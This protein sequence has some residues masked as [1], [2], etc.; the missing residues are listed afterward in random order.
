VITSDVIDNIT[1]DLSGKFAN[2]AILLSNGVV[3]YNSTQ[4]I[5]VGKKLKEW[6]YYVDVGSVI[7]DENEV[8]FH[9]AKN[10]FLVIYTDQPDEELV[11]TF[12]EIYE[13]YSKT[14]ELTYTEVPR[15]LKDIMKGIIFST[16]AGIK[17][18]PVAWVPDKLFTE[19]SFNFSLISTILLSVEMEDAFS[20]MVLPR[21]FMKQGLLGLLY[22]F[23]I[24]S[25]VSRVEPLDC[26]FVILV[27]ISNRAAV[28][29]IIMQIEGI[30]QHYAK[31]IQDRMRDKKACKTIIS[32]MFDTVGAI[33]L[34]GVSLSENIKKVMLHSVEEMRELQNPRSSLQDEPPDDFY[35]EVKKS[36]VKL[37]LT[38]P[39]LRSNRHI[40]IHRKNFSV[41][42]FRLE[43][44]FKRWKS[45]R[46]F[47][48]LEKLRRPRYLV[49]AL[50]SLIRDFIYLPIGPF[51]I[52]EQY[53]RIV[54]FKYAI[55]RSQRVLIEF[56]RA[57]E[58]QQDEFWREV[59]KIYAS[60][61][62]EIDGPTTHAIESLLS[63]LFSPGVLIVYCYVSEIKIIGTRAK[64]Y[65]TALE[66]FLENLPERYTPGELGDIFAD[67]IF[68]NQLFIVSL[69]G[70]P[71]AKWLLSVINAKNLASII[72]ERK[73]FK[74]K[75]QGQE[76][77]FDAFK[78]S[79][80]LDGVSYSYPVV[81][82]SLQKLRLL[83]KRVDF[84][85]FGIIIA[86]NS[87]F[88]MSRAFQVLLGIISATLTIYIALSKLIPAK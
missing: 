61:K 1:N 18:E 58:T 50:K 63:P 2:F 11:P 77:Q 35:A 64:P 22:L 57:D 74:H 71:E 15:S 21:P 55:Q 42:L 12:N 28:Y 62:Q 81:L 25:N 48:N 33:P 6:Q 68:K 51:A 40:K 45:A 47:Q 56:C 83:S 13:E 30:C 87:V 20:G 44:S 17:P 29:D 78:T 88:Y 24:S 53:E 86:G 34:R 69:P 4:E 70:E 8:V 54:R 46:S 52:N 38:L 75:T 7:R 43:Q 27:D 14:C 76:I 73:D 5:A 23:E 41:P 85:E 10:V 79:F 39:E 67:P 31:Q 80:D 3:L 66:S 72:N 37:P 32:E 60:F 36:I 49:G 84:T 9:L 82:Q 65:S 26:G 59:L 16:T 19:N